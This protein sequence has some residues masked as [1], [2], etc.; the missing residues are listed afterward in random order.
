MLVK[1]GNFYRNHRVY[2]TIMLDFIELI[3]GELLIMVIGLCV[4]VYGTRY[5][6]LWYCVRAIGYKNR[7]I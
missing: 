1:M 2:I 6:M 4:S 5:D 7:K 3:C